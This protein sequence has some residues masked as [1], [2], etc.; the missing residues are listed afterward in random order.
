M[1]DDTERRLERIEAQQFELNKA[2]QQLLVTNERLATL[3]ETMKSRE[4][5]ISKN[6]QD[7]HNLKL[8]LS[9]NKT[10]ISAVKW[11][12]VVVVGAAITVAVPALLRTIGTSI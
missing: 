6:E 7:I 12:A 8:E 11:L 10:I 2:V 5:R 1:P 9:N 4:P 3:M